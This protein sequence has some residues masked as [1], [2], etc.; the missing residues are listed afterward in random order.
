M[1]SKL[2]LSLAIISASASLTACATLTSAATCADPFLRDTQIEG[3]Y[4]T[5]R[6]L[7]KDPT[8]TTRD[9]LD[10]GGNVEDA[11]RRGNDDKHSARRCLELK[12]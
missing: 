11:V 10:F 2:I 6:D 9:A 1:L 3:K 7:L 4:R 12:P 5:Q 8:S